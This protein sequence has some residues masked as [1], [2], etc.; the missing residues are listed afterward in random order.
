MPTTGESSYVGGFLRSVSSYL[1]EKNAINDNEGGHSDHSS[2]SAETAPVGGGAW[3]EVTSSPRSSPDKDEPGLAIQ[4]A[5]GTAANAA[6]NTGDLQKAAT[7]DCIGTVADA[8]S[9]VV[10]HHGAMQ[11]DSEV[12]ALLDE[13]FD[14]AAHLEE[15]TRFIEV[16][17]TLG[18]ERQR[19]AIAGMA[20]AEATILTRVLAESLSDTDT[21]LAEVANAVVC[22]EE[23]HYSQLAE[24]MQKNG[25]LRVDLRRSTARYTK[26]EAELETAQRHV[27]TLQRH[28]NIVKNWRYQHAAVDP[29]S[30]QHSW[31]HTALQEADVEEA[32]EEFEAARLHHY[33]GRAPKAIN[34]AR[35][36]NP[37]AATRCI[38]S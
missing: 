7:N 2:E 6:W 37:K 22:L 8:S 16:Q 26:A 30:T 23:N 19:A 34:N 5:A 24:V 4:L 3:S 29:L 25:K 13:A 14:A 12:N 20:A 11:M 1:Y 18:S 17:R 31:L 33:S 38:I 9:G 10:L 36:G 15:Q 28:I 21:R 35:S 32:N 27:A